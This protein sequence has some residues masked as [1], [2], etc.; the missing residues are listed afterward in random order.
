[1]KFH[2]NPSSWNGLV[3][4]GKTD[5]KKLPFILEY[6]PHPNLFRTRV[7]RFLKRKKN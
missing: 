1:M 2:E 4:C 3:P 6:N 7:C 5:M